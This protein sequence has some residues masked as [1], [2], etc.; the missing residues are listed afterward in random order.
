TTPRDNT[1][2]CFSQIKS[3]ALQGAKKK[4]NL[5]S[6]LPSQSSLKGKNKSVLKTKIASRYK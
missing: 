6:L 1:E 4:L 5:K 2:I 3:R